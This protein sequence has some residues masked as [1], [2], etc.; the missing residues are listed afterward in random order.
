[1]KYDNK[2]W[3]IYNWKNWMMIHWILNPGLAF[4]ELILGQRVPKLY[5]VDIESNKPRI[6]RNFIPCPHCDKIHHGRT[7]GT[8]KTAFKNWF[9]LYCPDCG[10]IIP[11]VRNIFSLLILIVTFPI[12]GWFRNTLKENWLK[13][14][15][16]RFEASDPEDLPNPYEGWKW[17][18][19]AFFFGFFMFLFMTI[20]E[21]FHYSK[22]IL[23]N[24]L[25][26]NFFICLIAGL[27]FGYAM[28]LW[29]LQKF[30]G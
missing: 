2:K 5:L 19:S 25:L 16:K 9:G 23:F 24:E 13:K 15:P 30:R 6:D 29:S 3:K 26:L 8:K 11:C 18:N 1:M 21:P 14:Q 12:W 4:N 28:K 27:G 20:L 10:G 7:W 17:L 22:S